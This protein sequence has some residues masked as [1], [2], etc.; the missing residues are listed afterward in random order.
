[1]ELNNFLNL[2]VENFSEEHLEDV[3]KIERS[4]PTPWQEKTFIEVL[5]ARTLSS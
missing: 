3:F 2:S 1:M 4:N 5:K